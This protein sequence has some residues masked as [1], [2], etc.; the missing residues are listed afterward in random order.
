MALLEAS[1]VFSLN[2]NTPEA[3]NAVAPL[4][5]AELAV[6]G[7]DINLGV[8]AYGAVLLKQHMGKVC[9]MCSFLLICLVV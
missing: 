4:T 8:G 5:E 9:C 7:R 1:Q 3:Q 6:N 2:S